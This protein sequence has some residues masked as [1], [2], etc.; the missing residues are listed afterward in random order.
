MTPTIFAFEQFR[1]TV[2]EYKGEPV[3]LAR[4][5]GEALG[6][7]DDGGRF[8]WML[9]NEWS[10]ELPAPT[11]TLR[12]EGE[13]LAALKAG[14]P[15][16]SVGSRTRHLVL[17]TERGLYRSLMLAGGPKATAFRDWLDGEVLP[18]LRR[19]GTYRLSG[20]APDA[21]AWLRSL[22]PELRGLDATRLA[23]LAAAE[24]AVGHELP[25]FRA[26]LVGALQLEDRQRANDGA[27]LAWNRFRA[28]EVAPVVRRAVEAL[29]FTESDGFGPVRLRELV[30]LNR[31]YFAEYPREARDVAAAMG[32]LHRTLVNAKA[33]PVV[34]RVE[35]LD[36]LRAR[37][38]EAERALER[39]D[40][41]RTRERR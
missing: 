25:A 11:H 1:L 3:F 16:D 28:D 24:Q 37:I 36:R 4:E 13:D 6:Y 38:T 20:A 21:A 14:L 8:V 41:S 22:P 5:I 32:R 29:G 2:I 27:E 40:A 19:T 35:R 33:R 34:E 39:L 7:A 30:D 18:A 31:Q 23:D 17:L 10:G 26:A 15:T 12:L 9:G